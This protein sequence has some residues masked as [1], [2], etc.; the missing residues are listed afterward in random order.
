[1]A[2]QSPEIS[3]TVGPQV[4]P[5]RRNGLPARDRSS[6][7]PVGGRGSASLNTENGPLRRRD[8]H[9]RSRS[10][11]HGGLRWEL[12]GVEGRLSVLAP[13]PGSR[14]GQGQLL[15]YSERSR[16][17]MVSRSTS[18]APTSAAMKFWSF[19]RKAQSL[20]THR[21]SLSRHHSSGRVRSGLVLAGRSAATVS[22]RRAGR[23]G[24]WA[25]SH[26]IS[27]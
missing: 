21:S 5:R 25:R 9:A 12:W 6:Y 1:M 20:A 18:A 10:G 11:S 15:A 16:D 27:H 19:P 26:W 24:N 8:R 17:R 2:Y 23:T 7:P 4:H 3:D 14:G 13:V 22:G